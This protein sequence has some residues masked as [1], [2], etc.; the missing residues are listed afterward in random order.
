LRFLATLAACIVIIALA[1]G[2]ASA[3]PA[4]LWRD[5]GTLSSWSGDGNGGI[6]NSG[7]CA[8]VSEVPDPLGQLDRNVLREQLTGPGGCRAFRWRDANGDPIGAEAWFSWYMYLPT[9]APVTDYWGVWQ[10]KTVTPTFNDPKTGVQATG[11]TQGNSQGM[12]AGVCTDQPGCSANIESQTFYVPTGRWVNMEVHQLFASNATGFIEVYVDGTLA[13]ELR[14]IA[15]AWPSTNE[16]SRHVSWNSYAGSDGIGDY[17]VYHGKATISAVRMTDMPIFRRDV[18]GPPPPPPASPLLVGASRVAATPRCAGQTA[19]IVGTGRRDVLR[20]T[21]RRDVIAALGDNDL[22]RG[23]GGADLICLG[24]G[25]D[26]AIGGPGA[27]RIL[28]QGGADRLDGGPG[29]DV[30]QGGAGGDVLKGGA[31][32][33]LL[34]GGAGI[35]RLLGLAGRDVALRDPGADVCRVEARTDC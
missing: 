31:G 29:R 11:E 26:R 20:G 33:D 18:L 2:C 6:Y 14:N 7:A 35:D 19:T 13:G 24:A 27:D 30:L 10:S 17:T 23:L 1:D 4:P 25:S 28:G 8:S 22:V 34:L 12:V 3:A 5:A 9:L 15:T 16:G 32:G 21:A